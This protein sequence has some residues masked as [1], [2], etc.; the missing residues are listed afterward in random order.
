MGQPLEVLSIPGAFGRSGEETPG[1]FRMR[2]DGGGLMGNNLP[3]VN[4][5]SLLQNDFPLSKPKNLV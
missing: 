3:A 5:N 1:C 2:G 4:I